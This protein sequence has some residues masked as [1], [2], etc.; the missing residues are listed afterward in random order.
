MECTFQANDRVVRV[1]SEENGCCRCHPENRLRAEV[2]DIFTVGRIWHFGGG[3][4]AHGVKF[5]AGVA[6]TLVERPD[7]PWGY[8][9]HHFRPVKPLSFWIGEKKAEKVRA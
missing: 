2:G 8:Y 5:E 3:L 1:F 9:A 6:I 4:C 7:S